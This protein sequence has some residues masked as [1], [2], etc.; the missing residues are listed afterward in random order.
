M[1]LLKAKR[2]KEEQKMSND[3]Q[4]HINDAEKHAM[5]MKVTANK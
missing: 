3:A 2:A 5:E 1:E 4:K